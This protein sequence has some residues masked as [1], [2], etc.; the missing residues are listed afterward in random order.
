[1]G[2]LNLGTSH[3]NDS[4]NKYTIVQVLYIFYVYNYSIINSLK[5]G[6]IKALDALSPS[7][8]LPHFL[9]E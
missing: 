7:V 1:M 4:P 5:S 6:I 3:L 9:H 8:S 2:V